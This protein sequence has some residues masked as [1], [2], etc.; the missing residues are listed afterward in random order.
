M[1]PSNTIKDDIWLV[2]NMNV[3][4]DIYIVLVSKLYAPCGKLVFNELWYCTYDMYLTCT[5]LMRRL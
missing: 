1:T 4:V 3:N 5:S 2:F